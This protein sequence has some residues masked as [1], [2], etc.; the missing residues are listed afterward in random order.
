MRQAFVSRINSFRHAA[1]GLG[2]LI[3]HEPNARI[4]TAATVVVITL[5]AILNVSRLD[6]Y[7]LG[8]A[9]TIVWIAE[10]FNTAI[11]QLA[12]E[13]TLEHRERIGRAKDAAAAAVLTAAVGAG[14][15]GV[16]I[17]APALLHSVGG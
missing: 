15:I 9:I 16:T 12:D 6:W 11:E 14:A 2:W 4:H 3:A 17:F 13:V 7:W 10:T 8:A 5:G 1:R